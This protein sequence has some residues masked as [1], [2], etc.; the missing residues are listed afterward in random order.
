M[1]TIFDELP[2]IYDITLTDTNTILPYSFEPYIDACNNIKSRILFNIKNDG[3]VKNVNAYVW[4]LDGK[5]HREDGPA[6]TTECGNKLWYK[7]DLLHR[8]DGPAIIKSNG[9]HEW[10]SNGRLLRTIYT[11]K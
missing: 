2:D 9:I 4:K 5:L 8:E 1:S 6:V 11:F 10:Y 3:S 7:H